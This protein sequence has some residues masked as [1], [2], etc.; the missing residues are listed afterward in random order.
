M[1]PLA[2]SILAVVLGA[3][4]LYFGL[5]AN[6]GLS[7]IAESMEAGSI[8]AARIEKTLDAT[9]TRM[10]ELSSRVDELKKAL[11]RVRVYGSQ[12][13][14]AVKQMATAVKENREELVKIAEGLNE[15]AT[16]VPARSAPPSSAPFSSDS[17]PAASTVSPTVA[18]DGTYT[19]QAG[20]NFGKIAKTLGVGL[21]ELLDA[22]PDK[23]PRRLTIG[24]VI[25]VP[26]Q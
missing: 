20:D 3:A 9:E 19:I 7:P 23:D 24:T 26:A 8:S 15:V 17:A 4:G 14:R 6:Q 16:R 1:V 22:N 2:F 12:N 10:V 18:N 25:K 5:A 13:E 11:D 21:Q